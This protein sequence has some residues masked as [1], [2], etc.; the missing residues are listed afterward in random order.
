MKNKHNHHKEEEQPKTGEQESAA[1]QE[2]VAQQP[3][4]NVAPPEPAPGQEK[5]SPK[6]ED[7]A[8]LYFGQIIQLK[9]DFE[10]YRKRTEREKPEL[11]AWGRTQMVLKMLPLYETILKAKA[12][13][14]KAVADDK[15]ACTGV[16]AEICK[17]MDMIFKEFEKFFVSEK[18]E[19]ME[20][21][22]KPY[23]PMAHEVLTVLPCP[24]ESDGLVMAEVQ[25]GFM[26]AGKVIQPA[27][28]CI[29]KKQETQPAPEA[30]ESA[31]ETK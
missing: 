6:G 16:T 29:G 30:R 15:S 25:K 10:N 18:I 17:G 1:P 8:K 11:V 7:Q 14:D 13:L 23:D 12:Q 9:A 19:P 3:Q 20:T 27:K 5:E 26:C 31:Q 28:V 24:D 2:S 22:G 21:I 4:Q